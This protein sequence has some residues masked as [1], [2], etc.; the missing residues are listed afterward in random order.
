[1]TDIW[2]YHLT[3]LTLAKTLPKLLEKCMENNWRSLVQVGSPTTLAVLDKLLWSDKN[4]SF[5]AHSCQRDGNEM[6]QPIFLTQERDNPNNADV[7][8]M[9]DGAIPDDL[10][11]YKRA[12]YIFDGHDQVALESARERWKIEKAAGHSVSYW[13]QN[14]QGKWEKK[15]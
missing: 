6:D 15:A 1:M 5:L 2:F 12:I 8:F 3:E 13:Q 11:G 14:S 4:D 7:R 10:Q 9:V